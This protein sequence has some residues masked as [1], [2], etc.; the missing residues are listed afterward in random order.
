MTARS[1]ILAITLASPPHFSQVDTSM[2]KTRLRRWAF[3]PLGA[4]HGPMALFRCFVLIFLSGMSSA[5]VRIH[6]D[7]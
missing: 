7:L 3:M 6:V 2:L 1:S 4:G 5:S